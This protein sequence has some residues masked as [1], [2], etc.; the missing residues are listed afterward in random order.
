MSSRDQ[1]KRSN[2]IRRSYEAYIKTCR[3]SIRAEMIKKLQEQKTYSKKTGTKI[4]FKFSDLFVAII[5]KL[6]QITLHCRC[7]LEHEKSILPMSTLLFNCDVQFLSILSS[8]SIFSIL[9]IYIAYIRKQF[10]SRV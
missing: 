5:Y 8:L 10:Y 3:I 2:S 6:R 1:R 9:P 7:V 4:A